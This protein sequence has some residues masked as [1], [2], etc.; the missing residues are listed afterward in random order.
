[1]GWY[2]IK[3]QPTNQ[4]N[5]QSFKINSNNN[6][7]TIWFEWFDIRN[8]YFPVYELRLYLR[9]FNI[10][11]KFND[12]NKNS[13]LGYSPCL[14]L[15]LFPWTNNMNFLNHDA[16]K[17]KRWYKGN[18][19]NICPWSFQHVKKIQNGKRPLYHKDKQPCLIS[20]MLIYVRLKKTSMH[21]YGELSEETKSK[22]DI[23]GLFKTSYDPL[24]G[25]N[26]NWIKM[27]EG[28]SCPSYSIINI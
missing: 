14:W 8:I 24:G 26:R 11:K 7:Y 2:A 21:R 28:I 4:T 27:Q 9:L 19:T 15:S 12:E 17:P 1:M 5:K 3:K 18:W 23:V 16:L 6:T 20:S 10:I 13:I 22:G 25:D